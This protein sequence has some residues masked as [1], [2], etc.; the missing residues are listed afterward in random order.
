LGNDSAF[1]TLQLID[2]LDPSR[3]LELTYL[4]GDR[5]S[6]SDPRVK[7]LRRTFTIRFLCA[8]RIGELPNARVSEIDTCSYFLQFKTVYG[9]PRECGFAGRQMCGGHGLCAL[10]SS[11]NRPRCFCN[12]GKSG[13]FCTEGVVATPNRQCDSICVALAFVVVLLFLLIFAASFILYRV[14]KLDKLNLR[15]SAIGDG[16]QPQHTAV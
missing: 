5:C 2:P 11:T 3:G 9:C 8:D 15:F 1:S 7:D 14:R 6:S 10:D 4:S 16:E 12:E 13:L